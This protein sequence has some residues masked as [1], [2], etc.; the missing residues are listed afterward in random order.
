MKNCLHLETEYDAEEGRSFAIF[1][2]KNQLSCE[3][4][5]HH[6][7]VVS[8]NIYVSPLQ[9]GWCLFADETLYDIPF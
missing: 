6:E 3:Y 7:I 2:T 8:G 1:C 9:R 5:K 4:C